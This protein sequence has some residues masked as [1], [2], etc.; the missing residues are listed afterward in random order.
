MKIVLSIIVMSMI[1]FSLS[2]C[3]L[4]KAVYTPVSKIEEPFDKIYDAV[5]ED[6]YISLT[7]KEIAFGKC[8]LEEA[9]YTHNIIRDDF[10]I[11]SV[12][13]EKFQLLWGATYYDKLKSEENNDG[14][15]K[16]TKENEEMVLYIIRQYLSVYN[17][18]FYDNNGEI[19]Q[20]V[21][22]LFLFKKSILYVIDIF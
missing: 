16:V 20:G 7:S 13:G 12:T 5:G 17:M 11:N 10:F 21:Y 14:Y 19:K 8:S 3:S 4:V 9:R 2:S 15:I 18:P 6:V 1:I 22:D